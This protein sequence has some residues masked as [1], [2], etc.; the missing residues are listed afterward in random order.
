[1]QKVNISEIPWESQ[2]SPGRK[3]ARDQRR[4][5]EALGR[6]PRSTDIN[7]R[8]PFDVDITKIPPATASCPYHSHSAQWEFYIVISGRG[9]V[10]HA[11]GSMVIAP[12][13]AF[14]FKHNEPHQLIND[15][16]E[17]LLI[18]VVADNPV[19]ETC[20]YPDSGKWAVKSPEYRLMRSEPLDYY[21]GEE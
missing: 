8:H 21:D 10:R 4:I 17:D 3:F 11:E 13:D 20:Y 19:G 14:L 16:D 6:D 5:S 15:Q 12:G 9:K 1:M 7:K 18:Y 2:R